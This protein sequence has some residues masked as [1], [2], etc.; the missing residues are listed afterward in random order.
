MESTNSPTIIPV[1]RS[2][3]QDIR[4]LLKFKGNIPAIKHSTEVKNANNNA[5]HLLKLEFK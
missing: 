5:T 1:P 4:S 3:H 2:F